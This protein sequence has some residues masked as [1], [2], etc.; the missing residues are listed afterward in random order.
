MNLLKTL[1]PKSRVRQWVDI[2]SI[3]ETPPSY[4][5]ACGLSVIGAAFRRHIYVD[6]VNWKVFPMLRVLLVGPPGIGKDTAINESKKVIRA[7]GLPIIAGTTKEHLQDQI[8]LLLPPQT[9]FIAAGELAN[10]M[11]KSDY[12]S[13]TLEFLTDLFSDGD[14]LDASC[15]SIPDRKLIEPTIT[16]QAGST[17]EWLH[18]NLPKGSLDGGFLPRYLV[19][20]EQYPGK[21]IALPKREISKTHLDYVKR[22]KEQFYSWIKSYSTKICQGRPREAIWD[23]EAAK[24]YQHWYR[25]RAEAFPKIVLPYAQRARDHMLRLAMLHALS[26]ESLCIEQPD[27]SFAIIFMT[28]IAE[29]I[30]EALIPPTT[31]AQC[32]KEILRM[33]PSNRTT[34]FKVLRGKYLSRIIREAVETLKS[35]GEIVVT[36]NG[37]RIERV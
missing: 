3:T 21:H 6:Q 18:K 34:V 29:Q 25:N 19:V 7:L 12:Q 26:R 23:D 22:S 1:H 31:E 36:E 17:I 30:A 33:L 32:A 5:I 10:F 28:R 20:T 27:V 24:M 37:K 4:A 11:G 2:L 15:R 13:G 35:S 16:M 9:G 8:A 14:V